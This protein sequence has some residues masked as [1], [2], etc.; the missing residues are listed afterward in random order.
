MFVRM[1]VGVGMRFTVGMNVPV[2]MHEVCLLQQKVWP[3]ISLGVPA[4]ARRPVWKTKHRSAMSSTMSRSWAGDH[5]LRPAT[6]ADQEIDHLAGAFRI[7]RRRGFVQQQ[8]LGIEHQHGG[9]RYVFLLSGRKVVRRAVLEVSNLHHLQHVLH[10]LRAPSPWAT[11][12]ARDQR[13][14]HQ[15]LSG[16]TVAHPGFETPALRGAGTDKQIRDSANALR[17]AARRRNVMLPASGN[18]NPSRTRSSVDLPEPFAPSSATRCPG[19]I[20]RL[21]LLSAVT[22]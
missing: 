18:A 13:R 14:L 1:H 16:K 12:A 9:K 22:C 8:H 19:A 10:R 7:Q 21:R 20:A 2:D 11:E 3:R 17:S 15:T 5:G 6:Q 4:A